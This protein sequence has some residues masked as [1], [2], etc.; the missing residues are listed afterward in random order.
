M[1]AGVAMHDDAHP[2]DAVDR[3]ILKAT[4]AGLT[5]VARPYDAVGAEVGISGTQV[6]QRLKAMMHSGIV[7]R[8]SA[9]PN[10]YKLGFKANGMT[11]WDVDDPEVAELGMKIGALEYVSHCYHRPRRLPLWRYNLFA[12]VHGLDRAEVE[13]KAAAIAKMLGRYVRANEI[14]YS[15][16]ILKKTGL[17]I[18]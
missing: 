3:A 7:R 10:H 2:L 11:V 14:I 12:M 16:K 9:V 4:Q 5:L 1:N 13:A 15:Q 8:I 17:R 18:A 6:C